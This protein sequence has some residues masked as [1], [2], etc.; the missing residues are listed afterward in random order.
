MIG[1]E[2]YD[3]KMLSLRNGAARTNHNSFSFL[4]SVSRIMRKELFRRHDIFLVLWML[5]VTA[6]RNRNGILG[7]CRHDSADKSFLLYCFLFHTVSVFFPKESY[8]REL[9]QPGLRVPSL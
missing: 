5:H 8:E 1:L 6:D 9:C 4:F 3:Y 7:F 2:S